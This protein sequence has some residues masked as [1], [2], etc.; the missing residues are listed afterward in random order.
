[1]PQVEDPFHASL[2][3]ELPSQTAHNHVELRLA[4]VTFGLEFGF[5]PD[6]GRPTAFDE[7]RRKFPVRKSNKGPFIVAL[8]RLRDVPDSHMI[9]DISMASAGDVE[10][11]GMARDEFTTGLIRPK[12]SRFAA[13]GIWE[14]T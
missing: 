7:A 8:Q 4:V 9:C 2:G 6:A 12:F 11:H 10:G 5:H 3:R 1:M 14:M 13:R